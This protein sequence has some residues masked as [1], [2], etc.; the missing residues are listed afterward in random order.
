MNPM[1][2]IISH[3][4]I[5]GSFVFAI[6]GALTAIKKKLDPFGILIVSFITAVGGGT[7]RD[8]LL[9]ERDVFWLYETK[10][11][12]AVLT[13]GIIA[14][15][16]KD[17]LNF[18]NKPMFFYDSVGLGLFTITGVQIGLD[19]N[20]EPIICILL[21]TVTGVFGGVI[22]DVLVNKIPVIFKKEIYAT[23]SIFGGILYLVLTKLGIENPYVQ[24]IPIISIILIRILAVTF[25]IS[26]PNIYKK[27]K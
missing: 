3:I 10:I 22:R 19:A 6:S 12:Y 14:M 17:K 8:M 9:A 2:L 23:A 5:V 16:L 27:K 13:G 20:L 18:F 25:N 11:I 26:L 1:E 7:L 4:T 21:G 24:I 15:V